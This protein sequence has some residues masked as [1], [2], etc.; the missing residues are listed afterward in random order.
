MDGIKI[1]YIHD[2]S[3][4]QVI[5]H[6]DQALR[7]ALAA[8]GCEIVAFGLDPLREAQERGENALLGALQNEFQ[9][10][11]K[12]FAPHFAMGYNFTGVI[13]SADGAHVLERLGVPYFGMFYDNPLYF[14]DCV[15]HCRDKDM[16]CVFGIDPEFFAPLRELG[17]KHL[18]YLPIGTAAT[19]PAQPG[20]LSTPLLFVGGVKP[21]ESLEAIA[22]RHQGERRDF[23]LFA[24]EQVET[25]G[26]QRQ[27][28]LLRL[29]L[30]LH[31]QADR[32]F[33]RQSSLDFQR[34]WF[35]VDIRFTSRTRLAT[36]LALQDFGIT[37]VGGKE[38]VEPLRG[39]KVKLLPPVDYARLP[40]LY[41]AAKIV[42]NRSPLNLQ[43][44]VQQRCL[45]VAAS[46]GFVLTEYRPILER[47]FK[48][49]RELAI[50]HDLDNLRER[51][52][53]YLSHESK[54]QA[55]A[56]AG[57]AKVMAEHTW[58]RRAAEFLDLLA[59]LK[60]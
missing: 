1:L 54:R 49:G 51:V 57:H 3:G 55:V 33:F 53:Y 34:L 20:K 25:H 24:A 52:E 17:F 40:E 5:C 58:T 29:F 46:G 6:I 30:E 13:P 45:D 26:E 23:V 41:A 37:V 56:A 27:K 18:R 43:D 48:L 35:D 22:A 12:S 44:A 14:E 19:P 2:R 11:V 4:N 59:S 16:V 36:V 15:R 50:Y 28:E 47:H 60:E 10:L 42:V 32:E 31:P 38:W 9:R 21:V 39:S 8:Q 7:D